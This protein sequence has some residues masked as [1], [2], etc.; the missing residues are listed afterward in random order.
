M[1]AVSG[2]EERGITM[3]RRNRKIKLDNFR[4]KRKDIR[5]QSGRDCYKKKFV[6]RKN[7]LNNYELQ[8]SGLGHLE[9][10]SDS[11]DRRDVLDAFIY[12][13]ENSLR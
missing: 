1:F 11:C 7:E 9:F 6:R 3:P 10:S 5:R 13:F 2:V 12:A 4:K 8:V